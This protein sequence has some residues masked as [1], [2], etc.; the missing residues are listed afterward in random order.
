MFGF[1]TTPYLFLGIG[2]AILPLLIHL[3]RRNK[4]ELVHFAAIRF[5]DLTPLRLLRYQKL[6]HI[7]LLLLRILALLLL[8]LAFARPYLAGDKV[9]ALLGR[10]PRAIAIVVDASASMAA[11]AHFSSAREEARKI[12]QQASSSDRIW[13]IAAANTMELLAENEEA[14][15]VEAALTQLTQ[16]QTAGNLREALL[17]AD[18]LLGRAPLQRRTIYLISDLQMSNLPAGSFV[19]NSNAECV[20]I[21]IKP[22]WQNVAVL[23]GQMVKLPPQKTAAAESQAS[24][25][26]C[27]VRNF[28]DAD[29]LIEVRLVNNSVPTAPIAVKKISLA[30]RSEQAIQFSAKVLSREQNVYFEIKAPDDDLPVDNRFYLVAQ[31]ERKRRL[32]VLGGNSDAAYFVREAL[33]LPGSLYQLFEAT[34]NTLR[35]YRLEDFE[36]VLVVGVA[37]FNRGEAAALQQ[38]VE[39]GGGLIL[40]LAT[41]LQSEAYNRFLAEILPGKITAL[42][43]SGERDNKRNVALTEVDFGHPIFK[44]FVDPSNGDPTTVQV[45]QYHRVEAD[46]QSIRLAAFED[47]AAA[48]LERSAGKGKV[49]L[50]TSSLDLQSGNLPVRGIFVPMLYQWLNYVC[51]PAPPQTTTLVGQTLFWDETVQPN[52]SLTITFPDG[53]QRHF[54]KLQPPVLKETSQSG[55]YRAQ[56]NQRAFW[57][58]VNFDAHESDP[59]SVAAENFA[60]R[61]IRPDEQAQNSVAGIFG[62]PEVSQRDA[63]KQQKLWRLGLW[64]LLVLLMGEVWL[65]NRTPR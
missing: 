39:Q 46:P 29:Q 42:I 17:F 18:Q 26:A 16:R 30:A 15:K 4:P 41:T 28:S 20:P 43:R 63:E 5:L 64:A 10:E 1:L 12:L 3:I 47:G 40:T 2:A 54:E 33:R 34:P 57:H 49:L 52:Q 56:Q 53:S 60:A 51:R 25:Y 44:I 7:L 59:A 38:Y 37:G 24:A 35:Q 65:A 36:V 27:R 58:A 8:G 11:I 14:K 48:L 23:D 32:L 6:K 62:A 13:L 21:A 45:S 50:W 31:A 22:A 61:L 9:P 55:F 19:L